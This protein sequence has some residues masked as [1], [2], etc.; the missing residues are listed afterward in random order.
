EDKFQDIV[1]E[2]LDTIV[3]RSLPIGYASYNVLI[4]PTCLEEYCNDIVRRY[5]NVKNL[6][7]L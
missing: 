7:N 6:F 3:E 2:G 4:V 1:T 5:G